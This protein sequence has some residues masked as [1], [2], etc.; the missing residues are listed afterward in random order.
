MPATAKSIQ[1]KRW[2]L[3]YPELGTGPLPIEPYVSKEYCEREREKLF[4]RTWEIG[5]REKRYREF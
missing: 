3:E 2:T 5:K 1:T 4:K